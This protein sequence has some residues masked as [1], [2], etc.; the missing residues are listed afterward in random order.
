MDMNIKISQHA[1][2]RMRERGISEDEVR[3][4]FD[5]E[6]WESVDISD[7]DDSIIVVTKTFE[8]RKWRFLF[9]HETGT[10]VTCYPRR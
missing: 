2:L 4:A 8:G 5:E 10:L 7:M 1:G 3:K 6:S 9:N